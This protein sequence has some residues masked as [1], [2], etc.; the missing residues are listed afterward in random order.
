MDTLLSQLHDIDGL[1]QISWWPLAPGWIAL[2]VAIITIVL[3]LGIK[4]RFYKNKKERLDGL[5][6]EQCLELENSFTTLETKEALKE[7]SKIIRVVAMNKYGRD[8]CARLSQ[9]EWLSWLSE[10]D[11]KGFNWKTDASFL[12]TALY[13]PHD[14]ELDHDQYLKILDAIKAWI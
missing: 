6:L 4:A 8:Q 9:S 13:S 7:L 1:D 5:L 2:I 14:Y 3:L 10:N 11:P 12:E